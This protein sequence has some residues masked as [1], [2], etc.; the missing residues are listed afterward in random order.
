[1]SWNISHTF[2]HSCLIFVC[3]EMSLCLIHYFSFGCF[4]FRSHYRHYSVSFSVRNSSFKLGSDVKLA[5]GNQTWTKTMF[6]IWSINLT[7]QPELCK[8]ALDISER[9][10]DTCRD[11]KSLHNTSS[12]QLYLHI[13]NFSNKD[14]GTYKCDSSY[15]GGNDAHYINVNIIGKNSSMVVF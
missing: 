1:M 5:C 8:I 6:I 3:V 2:L 15:Y 7:I 14:V 13:P 4:Y 12:G 11:G 10:V 9:S